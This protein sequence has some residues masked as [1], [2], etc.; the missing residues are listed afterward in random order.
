MRFT[1]VIGLVLLLQPFL[2]AQD[3]GMG[4]VSVIRDERIDSVLVNYESL[5]LKLMENPDTKLI[6]GYRIQ[7]FFDSGLNS[8]DRARQTRD[9]FLLLFPD[10]PAYVSWKAPNYRV[11]VGDYKSRLD[12]EKDLQLIMISY[13][14]AW[15][16][17]DEINFPIMK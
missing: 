8:S 15:V 12:A 10:I 13:P 17:K 9:E 11:R 5:R 7:I 3:A 16:T 1:L 14:N 2:S 6:P 4:H